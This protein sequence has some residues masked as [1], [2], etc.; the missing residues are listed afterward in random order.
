MKHPTDSMPDKPLYHGKPLSFNTFLYCPGNIVK[1]ISWNSLSDPLLQRIQRYIQQMGRAL[2]NT[3]YR[4][5]FCGVSVKTLKLN[6]KIN[7]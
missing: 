1:V 3:S 6:T 2:T 5:G 7:G 4:K